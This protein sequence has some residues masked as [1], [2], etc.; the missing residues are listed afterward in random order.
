[1]AFVDKKLNL[2]V[3]EMPYP[4]TSFDS[5]VIQQ[6]FK[7]FDQTKFEKSCESRRSLNCPILLI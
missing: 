4:V 6:I 3:C 7:Y 1:M 5:F 2:V